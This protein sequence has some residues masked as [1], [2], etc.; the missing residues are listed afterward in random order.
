MGIRGLPE[1]QRKSE[2]R[3]WTDDRAD[4]E[5]GPGQPGQLLS[6][7]RER[8]TGLRFRYGSARCDPAGGAG[9]AQLRTAANHPRAAPPQLGGE[10]EAGLQADARGQSALCAEAEVRDDDR[11]QSWAESLPEPGAA[12]GADRCRSAL[13]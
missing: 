1:G 5:A 2:R 12:D 6:L 13:A 9:M 11:F 3:R 4:G 8:E 10:L 7:R